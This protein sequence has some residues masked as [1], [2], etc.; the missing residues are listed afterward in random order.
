M[1]F[2]SFFAKIVTNIFAEQYGQEKRTVFMEALNDYGVEKS[3]D[4]NM[5]PNDRYLYE[6]STRGYLHNT[7]RFPQKGSAYSYKKILPIHIAKFVTYH[8]NL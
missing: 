4:S 6:T 1:H 5:F 8:M 7:N 3:S 2:M